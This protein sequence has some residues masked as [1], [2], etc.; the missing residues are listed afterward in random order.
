MAQHDEIFV[1]LTLYQVSNRFETLGH[2]SDK[3]ALKLQ[4]LCSH[5]NAVATEN[6]TKNCLYKRGLTW[7]ERVSNL[8]RILLKDFDP[9]LILN[10]EERHFYD[11]FLL[12][13]Y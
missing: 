12:L 4:V 1:A 9:D 2:G 6:A 8:F 5:D 10:N 3:M 13:F 11:I 7:N